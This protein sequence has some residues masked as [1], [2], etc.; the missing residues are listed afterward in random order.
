MEEKSAPPGIPEVVPSPSL[1]DAGWCKFLPSTVGG[2][3]QVRTSVIVFY[4][5]SK[6][7]E[8]G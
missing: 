3:T 7:H 4:S 8:N 6:I 5:L 1:C 2:K